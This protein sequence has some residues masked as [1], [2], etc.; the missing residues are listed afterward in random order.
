[1]GDVVRLTNSDVVLAIEAVASAPIKGI[2]MRTALGTL[3]VFQP[4]T[5]EDLG[6]R[7]RVIWEGSDYRGRGRKT[8]WEASATLEDDAFE[9]MAPTT[10][11]YDLHKRFERS[12]Q[13]IVEWTALTTRSFGGRDGWLIDT[14]VGTLRID[15]ALVKATIS[16]AGVGRDEI[17]HEAGTSSAESE[18]SACPTTIAVVKRHRLTP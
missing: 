2:E 9:R 5:E 7:I 14:D 16:G 12:A 10:N 3:E 1:M 13:N 4:F 18:C 8:I 15:T 11:Q 6:R 17:V